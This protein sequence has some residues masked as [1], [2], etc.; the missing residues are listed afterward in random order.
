MNKGCKGERKLSSAQGRAG[1]DIEIQAGRA[2]AEAGGPEVV[3]AGFQGEGWTCQL[4]G[5]K[6][7]NL[8]AWMPVSTKS[9]VLPG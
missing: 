4:L 7:G 9:T 5:L 2:K 1:M 8:W 6:P 3:F